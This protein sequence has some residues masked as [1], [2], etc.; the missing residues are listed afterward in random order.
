M[1]WYRRWAFSAFALVP[2]QGQ[3]IVCCFQ[4]SKK[5]LDVGAGVWVAYRVVS[6]RFRVSSSGRC[7]CR[8]NQR[9]IGR[10]PASIESKAVER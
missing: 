10:F 1:S 2:N 9:D 4:D 6:S 3:E 5:K 7:V 8:Q